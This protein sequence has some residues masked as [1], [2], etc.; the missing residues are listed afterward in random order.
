M[1]IKKS[2]IIKTVLFLS[3]IF[4]AN[5]S[6]V[7]AQNSFDIENGFVQHPDDPTKKVEYF[8]KKPVKSGPW[9]MVVFLHGHQDGVRPG[10]KVFDE[11]G[12]LD[13][14]AKRGYL[15]VAVSQP[16]YGNSTGPADFCGEA[17]Q[18]AVSAVISHLRKEGFV[19][20]NKLV[21]QGISRGAM[22]ASLIAAHD[23]SV[24]GIIL[25]SGLY[26]LTQFVAEANKNQIKQAVMDSLIAE[27]GGG[28]EAL[29]TRS[30]LPFAGKI[31]AATL[32]LNGEKDDRTDPGQARRLAEEITRSGGKARAII[33]PEYGHQ[34]PVDVRN[35]E[36]D[37]FIENVLGNPN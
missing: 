9:P 30:A 17:T 21:I 18:N 31:K 13:R 3:I 8:M 33:Y 5:I 15:A 32:I 12:V 34:I 1:T 26:D 25:I 22:V 4:L 27:T 29:R 6:G 20:K 7:K 35:K 2:A 19:A 14:F 24:S 11:W 23:D 16:G 36:I 28:A 10:G 37:P